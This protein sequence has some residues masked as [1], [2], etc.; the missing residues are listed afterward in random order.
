MITIEL[1]PSHVIEYKGEREKPET[2]ELLYCCMQDNSTVACTLEGVHPVD[3]P[4]LLLYHPSTDYR[5]KT[6]RDAFQ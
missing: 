5:N 6:L 2:S 4:R 1:K 3:L